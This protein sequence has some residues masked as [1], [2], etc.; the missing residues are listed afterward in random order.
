MGA[1]ATIGAW[2]M[3]V[4]AERFIRFLASYSRDFFSR[5]ST[6]VHTAFQRERGPTSRC[7]LMHLAQS[8]HCSTRAINMSDNNLHEES[9]LRHETVRSTLRLPRIT[10]FANEQ[11]EI[12]SRTEFRRASPPLHN[13]NNAARARTAHR[14]ASGLGTGA[15]G[16]VLGRQRRVLL[17][18]LRAR[19]RKR[20]VVSRRG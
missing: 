19:G 9:L 6:V 10:R 16:G 1:R 5:Y 3:R 18:A 7:E 17:R 2:K 11:R 20:S 8:P 14:V 12:L 15:V 13:S 4:F